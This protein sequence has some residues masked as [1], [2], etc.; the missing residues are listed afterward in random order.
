M[1]SQT[2]ATVDF[3]WGSGAPASG[4]SND[5]FSV[6]WTGYVQVPQAGA[7]TFYTSSRDGVRL[8][9]GNALAIDNWTTHPTADSS[10]TVTLPVGLARVSLEYFS[11]SPNPEVHLS[12]SG[13]SVASRTVIPS[14]SLTAAQFA[15]TRAIY[16]EG[17]SGL[18]GAYYSGTTLAGRPAILRTD[19]GTNSSFT[20]N[21]SSGSWP[22]SPLGTT[23]FSARW[24]GQ[25]IIP[26]SGT[27]LIGAIS[28]DG[29]R[30][31]LDGNVVA[32]AWADRA[33]A[34]TDSAPMQLARG[35][36]RIVAEFYQ[37]QGGAQFNLRWEQPGATTTSDVPVSSLVPDYGLITTAI[38]V[39]GVASSMSYTA[40]GLDA[41]RGLRT[42]KT[43]I[44]TDAD[45]VQLSYD[46]HT[47]FDSLGRKISET[48]PKGMA[49]GSPD[50][51]YTTTYS[52]FPG[53]DANGRDGLLSAMTV[54]GRGT[55][56]YDYERPQAGGTYSSGRITQKVDQRGTWTY[57]Y[58]NDGLQTAVTPPGRTQPS[59]T[60]FDADGNTL[61]ISD[62]HD[63]TITYT[64]DE[65][66]RRTGSST[67]DSFYGVPGPSNV[68]SASD[69]ETY[70][71]EGHVLTQADGAGST[72]YHY[73]ARGLLDTVTDPANRQIALAYD[74]G[75]RLQTKSL[76][77]NTIVRFVRD[78]A[79]RLTQL[80]NHVQGSPE[81]ALADYSAAYDASG[82]ITSQ[83]GPDGTSSYSYDTV[84]HL[85]TWVSPT[86]ARTRYYFDLDSNRTQQA[87]NGAT[88]HSYTYASDATDRLLA[89][90]SSNYS[91][92]PAGTGDTA[93]RP[94]QSFTWDP[95]GQLLTTTT[96][97]GSAS[98][99]RDMLGRVRE[100]VQKDSSGNVTSD[101]VY[102]FDGST[103][104]AAYESNPAGTTINRSYMSAGDGLSVTYAGNRQ[105]PAS[106]DYADIHGNIVLTADAGGSI[107]SGPFTY[108]PFGVSTNS[109]VVSPYGF[110]GKW[111][112][113]TDPLSALVVM[114]A[115]PYDP[116][117][118]RFLSVDPVRGGAAND[119]DYVNQDPVNGYDLSGKYVELCALL[120]VPGAGELAC[121]AGIAL[122]L[123]TLAFGL[124][125]MSRNQPRI[126]YYDLN[127]TSWDTHSGGTWPGGGRPQKPRWKRMVWRGVAIVVA[128]SGGEAAREYANSRPAASPRPSPSPSASPVYGPPEPM[129]RWRRNLE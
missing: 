53:A 117:L 109:P 7:W 71:L 119:Y 21:I 124:F 92:D 77:N 4:V 11:A 33:P 26:A 97:N 3:S 46:W 43:L 84:G 32:Q 127:V 107:T 113:L 10:G 76:P 19:T 87:V 59:V 64:Y 23:V 2:D 81:T 128:A 39:N 8:R 15:T 125:M 16:D 27:Y 42:D 61:R 129:T 111:Q 36:H 70:D 72:S 69:S 18:R 62:P 121:G 108:D 20:Y 9:V 82:R 95:F 122:T 14:G 45:G 90:D 115:R 5:V 13:P 83:T 22:G 100:R 60:D 118:G 44:N 88:T 99:T 17:L 68:A 93:S 55:T 123:G 101:T 29:M 41:V 28:D 37:N 48:S 102:R 58:D 120:L 47:T 116:A 91:Y 12:W 57:S 85:E 89:V 103:D 56:S 106:F 112:K 78:A 75:G 25:L 80:Q 63:G 104:A 49:G 98:Y 105:A 65:L 51:N 79:G 67:Y 34:E 31:S 50:P 40:G 86:T 66:D 6:R 54:P 30:V 114:G 1:A 38:D 96:T 35:A 73:D 24:T 74:A 126:T 52:Y 94:G 110:V